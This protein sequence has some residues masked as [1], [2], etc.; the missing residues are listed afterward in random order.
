M[1]LGTGPAHFWIQ[2]VSWH[3]VQKPCHD[4]LDSAA[5]WEVFLDY[6]QG[7]I[8]TQQASCRLHFDNL[9]SAFSHR[10]SPRMLLIKFALTQMLKP[11]GAVDNHLMF[12]I[13]DAE[14]R[15]GVK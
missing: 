9:L 3:Q 14:T 2:T 1:P 10:E 4:T 12:T 6:L 7:C 13:E 11:E 5:G 15:C 8:K